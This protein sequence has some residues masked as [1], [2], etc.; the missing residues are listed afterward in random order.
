MHFSNH[1]FKCYGVQKIEAIVPNIKKLTIFGK[2]TLPKK[3]A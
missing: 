3:D 2:I 1:S